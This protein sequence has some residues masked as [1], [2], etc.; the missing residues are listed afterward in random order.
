MTYPFMG[1]DEPQSPMTREEYEAIFG[2]GFGNNIADDWRDRA[3]GITNKGGTDWVDNTGDNRLSY[4]TDTN[5]VPV[6]DLPSNLD[7]LFSAED[8]AWLNSL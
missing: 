7:D 4:S 8:R 2:K 1:S 5:S 6:D 3:V